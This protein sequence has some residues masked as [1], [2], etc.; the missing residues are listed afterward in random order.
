[1]L[2]LKSTRKNFKLIQKK[3][4][5]RIVT[6]ITLIFSTQASGQILI[7]PNKLPLCTES[8]N[9]GIKYNKQVPTHKCWDTLIFENGDQY[10]GEFKNRKFN[11]IGVYTTENGNKY[12]GYFEDGQING[13]GALTSSNGLQRREGTWKDGKIVREIDHSQIQQPE[14]D[15]GEKF[16]E[17]EYSKEFLFRG[18]LKNGKRIRGRVENVNPRNLPRCSET[19]GTKQWNNCW[20]LTHLDGYLTYVWQFGEW[21]NGN[22][23]GLGIQRNLVDR[24][25]YVGNFK[26]GKFHGYGVMTHTPSL[27]RWGA[28]SDYNDAYVI[29]FGF[30]ENGLHHGKGVLKRN[31]SEFWGDFKNGSFTGNGR[32]VNSISGSLSYEGEFKNFEQSGFGVRYGN[33]ITIGSF[34]DGKLN[35][36]GVIFDENGQRVSQGE[37]RVI[38]GTYLGAPTKKEKLV[39]TFE[40]DLPTLLAQVNLIN[41]EKNNLLHKIIQNEKLRSSCFSKDQIAVCIS[42]TIQ[43]P[44]KFLCGDDGTIFTLE[45]KLNPDCYY[46]NKSEIYFDI[47][48]KNNLNTTVFD[49]EIS[50][51]QIAKSDTVL[52][53]TK[54]VVYDKWRP[55]EVKKIKGLTLNKMDQVY[56]V[57][58]VAAKWKTKQ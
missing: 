25:E 1:M 31:F 54:K 9:S 2:L 3:N 5:V 58:C 30:W 21:K 10:V 40:V 45:N 19:T 8:N 12:E 47:E 24:N 43:N 18:V 49:I 29:Y 11:G 27:T 41:D 15:S 36:L 22:L 42:S 23:N 57:S 16:V 48:I 4:N 53:R 20:G 37:W 13:L 50:C 17:E 46:L 34:L 32:E 51:E 38:E 35:G 28:R 44:N 26:N 55:A 6:L 56:S 14:L 7:N 39:A 33:L 52:L